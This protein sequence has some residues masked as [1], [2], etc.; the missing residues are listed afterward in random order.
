MPSSFY[1]LKAV[2]RETALPVG[3]ATV[4]EKRQMRT[5]SKKT[6][7]TL[8]ALSYLADKYA[9]G[10]VLISR[11]A[12]D[13]SI[14]LKFLQQILLQLKKNRIVDSRMGPGGGYFLC[15]APKDISIGS[16]IRRVEGPLAPLPCASDTAFR[17][18]DECPDA[19][20]CVTRA[21]LRQ[22]RDATAEIL[23]R[24]TLEDVRRRTESQRL[25][26]GKQALM[27]YI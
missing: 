7:Y 8:R 13:E 2:F 26:S 17:K 12:K 11:M 5:L 18:C 23:D 16:I 21:I 14:P 10:P 27:Y 1:F 6:Q 3:E 4:L 20:T 24:T 19:E 22:V 15:R 25:S 9:E